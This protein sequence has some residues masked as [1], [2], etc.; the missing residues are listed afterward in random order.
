MWCVACHAL[1]LLSLTD[2]TLILGLRLRH[3]RHL[4]EGRLMIFGAHVSTSGGYLAAL[5]YAQ[6]VGCEC[7]QLFAKSPRQW[8][9]PA[10]KVEA[11]HEFIAARQARGFGPVFTHT[12]YLINLSTDK[13]ELREKSVAALADEIVRGSILGADGVVTHIGNVPDGDRIAAATR[14]G[15]AIREAFELAG[16]HGENTRLLLENTAGAGSTFGSTFEEICSSVDA[17][18]LPTA[19]LGVCLDTCHAFAYGYRV[20]HASGWE[21]VIASISRTI[22]VDRLGLIHAN[23]CKFEAGTNHDRHEWIGDGHIGT[24]GFSAMVCAEPLKDVPVVT[25]MPGEAPEKD[26][27][28]VERLKAL[29]DVC[30]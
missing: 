4:W 22:G 6:S 25:E 29:R 21:E 13:A 23:D 8:R 27:V 14:T 7:L 26:R 1:S 18:G 12:A 28:N 3:R 9:G 24:Q 30:A 17:A 15:A 2:T 20:D 5:D 11:A 16:E 19:R 10:P